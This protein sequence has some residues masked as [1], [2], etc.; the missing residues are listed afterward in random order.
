LSLRREGGQAVLEVE[1]SH[2]RMDEGI[3][4]QIFEPFNRA[5]IATG[6]GVGLGLHLV[7]QVAQLHGGKVSAVNTPAGI[8]FRVNLPV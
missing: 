6:N 1:N 8:A 5:G 3:L 2:P 4:E 7:R